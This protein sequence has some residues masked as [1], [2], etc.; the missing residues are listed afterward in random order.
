MVKEE[1][2]INI[3]IITL[4]VSLIL[5]LFFYVLPQIRDSPINNYVKVECPIPIEAY[6][7]NSSFMIKIIKG[8]CKFEKEAGK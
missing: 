2:M 8:S 3:I 4:M 5:L 1:I 6:A 7:T